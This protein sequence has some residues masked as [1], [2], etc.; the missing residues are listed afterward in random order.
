M[1]TKPNIL[2]NN[3]NAV[4]GTLQT[5]QGHPVTFT[6]PDEYHS[7]LNKHKVIL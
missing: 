2:A 4:S 5:T 6:H 1:P 3:V 7:S